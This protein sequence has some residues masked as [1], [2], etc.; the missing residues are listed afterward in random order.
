MAVSAIVGVIMVIVFA[1]FYGGANKDRLSAGSKNMFGM[2]DFMLASAIVVSI[3]AGM[4]YVFMRR[5]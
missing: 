2:V 5:D 4:I 3:A 1:E